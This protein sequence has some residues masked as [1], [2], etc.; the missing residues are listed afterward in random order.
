[1]RPIVFENAIGW[2]T[3]APG[4]RGVVIAGAHGFEDLCSRHFLKLLADRIA[5]AGCPVMQFDYPGCGNSTGDAMQP[6][7]VE[8]WVKSIGDATDRLK[9]DTGV[10]D[11]I[12]AGFRLGALL[13]PLA[14][15]RRD[16]VAGLML[17]APPSSGRA[18]VREMT[19]LS[20]MI[21]APLAANGAPD[22]FDGL[23]VAGFR[24]PHETLDDLSVL[25]WQN[26]L[27]GTAASKVMIFT[28]GKRPAIDGMPQNAIEFGEF[29]G[30]NLLMCDPTANQIPMR[31][32]E[33]C[34][35]WVA[36]NAGSTSGDSVATP[37]FEP[38]ILPGD[39]YHE[40]PVVIAGDLPIR[41]VL[42]RP[43]GGQATDPLIFLNAGGVPHVGWARGTVEATRALAVK[44][45]ASLR[46]DLPGLGQ[47]DGPPGGRVFLYDQ[48]TKL[49]VIRAVDWM[50][51][52]GFS[53]IGLVGTC[54]G[55]FQAFH[56]ARADKRVTRLV[57]INPLCFSWNSSYALELAVWKTYETSK[58]AF[59]QS[60]S[61][62]K[63]TSAATNKSR[64]RAGVFRLAR[65]T[66][67]R[68]LE[69]A[70]T[71]LLRLH[72]LKLL[73]GSPVA[74]WMQALSNRGVQILLV[75]SQGDL[76][77]E[78]I[79]RHFGPNGERLRAMRG[80]DRLTLEAADHTLTP[81]H[82]RRVLIERLGRFCHNADPIAA[83]PASVLRAKAA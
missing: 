33:R 42:C 21:D 70:K 82:A 58:V 20:R 38:Q 22:T 64:L 47:S 28:N 80:V 6:G 61:T 55:A 39:G 43:D 9:Q 19:A 75:T 78:E 37:S 48:R 66:I 51:R 3:D 60:H 40:E 5:A 30:Y 56:A 7:L 68:G 36:G 52:A 29:D 77:L 73:H 27:A 54:S 25:N 53:R 65:H 72:P 12:L 71:M 76:S 46:I 50:E 69:V 62:L 16:D 10:Q 83:P 23:Q 44:G 79:D 81:H 15:A 32:L 17:L 2:L 18:Y 34:A 11:V 24:L 57:M 45:I 26:D 35:A 1:M 49:A 63:E 59:G 67:R 14:A 41:G 13:A 4:S 74:G 8:A 31:T